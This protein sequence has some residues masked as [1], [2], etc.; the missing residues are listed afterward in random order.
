MH[1]ENITIIMRTTERPIRRMQRRLSPHID[2]R[3]YEKRGVDVV[4][5]TATAATGSSAVKKN[6]QFNLDSETHSVNCCPPSPLTLV[7]PC[8]IWYTKKDYIQM[9][10]REAHLIKELAKTFPNSKFAIDGVESVEYRRRKIERVRKARQC[11]LKLQNL[12]QEAFAMIYGK[13]ADVS[14]TLA[15]EKGIYNANEVITIWS[16][17]EEQEQ[18]PSAC[19]NVAGLLVERLKNNESATFE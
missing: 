16:Q 12:P 7:K 19:G 10:Q 8:E 15:H 13:S 4:A 14:A 2:A 17:G 3:Q 18:G 11:V 6:V 5:S 1:R 9:K